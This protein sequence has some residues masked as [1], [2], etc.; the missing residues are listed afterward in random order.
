M[1]FEELYTQWTEKRLTQE[2]DALILGVHEH[3]FRRYC[4]DYEGSCGITTKSVNSNLI[5]RI[6]L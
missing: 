3:T 2:E 5:E 4:R 6:Y 1:C